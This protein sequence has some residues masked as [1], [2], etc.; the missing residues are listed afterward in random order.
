VVRVRVR[1]RQEDIEEY[2]PTEETDRLT[3]RNEEKDMA[4]ETDKNSTHFANW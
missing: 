4:D 2:L 1:K 3:D